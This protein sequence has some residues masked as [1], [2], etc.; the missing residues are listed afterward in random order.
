MNPDAQHP[1]RTIRD[2][3]V[4]LAVATALALTSCSNAPQNPISEDAR[5]SIAMMGEPGAG[6]SPFSDDA[7]SLSRW[8]TVESLLMLDEELRAQPQLATDWEQLDELT[9][10]FVLREGVTFHDGTP[11]DAESVKRSFDQAYATS[12]VPRVLS[13]V[14]LETEVTGEYEVTLTTDVPDP[15]LTHRLASPQ[16]S[17]LAE[18][19]Y[20]EGGVVNPVGSGTGPFVLTDVTGTTSASLDRYDEYWGDVAQLAG[21]DVAFV[22]DA[23]AR[24]AALRTGEVDV[25]EMIPVSQAAN[26]DEELLHE[27]STPRSTYLTLNMTSGPFAD[28]AIREA[29]R[30][31]IDPS[32]VAE[33]VYEG[34]ADVASGLLGGAIPWAAAQRGETD[35]GV[36]PAEVS[37]VP[38]TLATY[39]ERAENPEVAVQLQSQLEAAG[40]VVTQDV[41]EYVNMEKDMLAGAFDA[42]IMSRSTLID[43]GDPLLFLAQDFGCDGNNN[44]PQLCDPAVEREL[45][46][47]LTLAAG[48]DRDEATSRAETAILR[49]NAVVPLVHERGIQGENGEFSGIERDPMQRRLITEYTK[50]VGG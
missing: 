24:A 17:I 9:W 5:I 25:A 33:I 21:I 11:F 22:I 10:R 4:P 6:L 44:V 40:F 30:Q 3:V 43:T 29:A 45:R 7:N 34:R 46:S 23:A 15:L 27:I 2:R 16:L 48:V 26:L 13:G 35:S 47:G 31:A 32:P 42:V 49:T 50:P 19:A 39:R 37:G 20:E 12:S 18:R 28:P 41:R 14:E 1:R 36:E 8:R 38:I